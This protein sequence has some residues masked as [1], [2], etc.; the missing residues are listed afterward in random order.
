MISCR[1]EYRHAAPCIQE[2]GKKWCSGNQL[3][4]VFGRK[5]EDKGKTGQITGCPF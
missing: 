4:R 1:Q 2:M 5:Q 3:R